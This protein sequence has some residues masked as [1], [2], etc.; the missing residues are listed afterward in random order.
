MASFANFIHAAA[1]H[2]TKHS[3]PLR[4]SR[5]S[6]LLSS[7]RALSP[8][9]AGSGG[10]RILGFRP[11]RVLLFCLTLAISAP[12]R[13][14]HAQRSL[15]LGPG[16]SGSWVSAQCGSSLLLTVP[17][18]RPSA[19]PAFL[20]HPS[21]FHPSA[22]PAPR[23]PTRLFHPSA[24]PGTHRPTRLF[25]PS[26]GPEKLIHARRVRRKAIGLLLCAPL[27]LAGARSSA[28]RSAA[29]CSQSEGS[30]RLCA[31]VCR[32]WVGGGQIEL[33]APCL[34]AEQ[35]VAGCPR[36]GVERAANRSQVEKRACG[37]GRAESGARGALVGCRGA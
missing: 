19:G 10:L 22:G 24:G 13:V 8:S 35:P 30:A 4:D 23:R 12:V 33:A 32:A 28:Q 27:R 20:Q 7:L 3:T 29:V 37:A 26:A 17:A 11:V 34:C 15:S 21:H 18:F 9:L 31:E 1:P 6:S 2:A 14:L 16:V 36:I 5:V 25:R